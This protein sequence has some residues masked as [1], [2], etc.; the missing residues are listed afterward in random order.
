MLKAVAITF[1]KCSLVFCQVT[2]EEE[3]VWDREIEAEAKQQRDE[4]AAAARK[5][6][7][8]SEP[9]SPSAAVR[10]LSCTAVALDLLFAR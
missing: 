8:P 3:E 9:N 10:S 1:P 2:E 4:K 6:Q 7:P 5:S